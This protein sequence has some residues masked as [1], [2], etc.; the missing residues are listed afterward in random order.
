MASPCTGSSENQQ[1]NQNTPHPPESLE[2]KALMP[3]W[4]Q[5]ATPG[6]GTRNLIYQSQSC[7]SRDWRKGDGS[8]YANAKSG[9][10]SNILNLF[11]SFSIP[12]Y[13]VSG[14]LYS[15]VP[16]YLILMV[17][18]NSHI[19]LLPGLISK[20]FYSEIFHKGISVVKIHF[21]GM[22]NLFYWYNLIFLINFLYRQFKKYLVLF[23]VFNSVILLITYLT[24][25]LQKI[26][27]V[28]I[29][30]SVPYRIYNIYIYIFKIY[31]FLPVL[32]TY[33]SYLTLCKFKTYK[34]I[35]WYT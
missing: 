19:F 23:S 6:T 16:W 21:N 4:H 34:V 13:A 30:F 5:Q 26:I 35:I 14:Q 15:G 10:I 8:C 2:N 28:V 31:M 33:N 18:D 11:F 7:L 24:F 29:H 22:S 1:A 25:S 32:M 9:K 3:N 12:L 27:H 17:L 20:T